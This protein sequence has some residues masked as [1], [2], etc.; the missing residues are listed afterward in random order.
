MKNFKQITFA[1]TSGRVVAGWEGRLLRLPFFRHQMHKYKRVQSSGSLVFAEEATQKKN[2]VSEREQK[3]ASYLFS[4]SRVWD[5]FSTFHAL[6]VQI[7]EFEALHDL[8][9]QLVVVFWLMLSKLSIYEGF[10]GAFF[11]TIPN[12]MVWINY[13]GEECLFLFDDLV[14][15]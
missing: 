8:R 12:C 13:L 14:F 4:L 15:F 7:I 5:K 9:C 10:V 2:A 6:F 11:G 3:N 1:F